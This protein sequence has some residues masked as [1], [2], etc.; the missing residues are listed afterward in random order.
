MAFDIDTLRIK[1]RVAFLSRKYLQ[2]DRNLFFLREKLKQYCFVSWVA[3]AREFGSGS[4][5]SFQMIL[6]WLCG[7]NIS[8]F[9][10]ADSAV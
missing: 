9:P 8:A 3:L 2:C 6:F 4:G 7:I 10:K 5:F 1:Y